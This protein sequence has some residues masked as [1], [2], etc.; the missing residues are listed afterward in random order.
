MRGT[1]IASPV[2]AASTTGKPS[3][4]WTKSSG[5]SIDLDLSLAKQYAKPLS[6]TMNQL[7][8][9]ST[10]GQPGVPGSRPLSASNQGA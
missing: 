7:Q 6:P 3:Q 9:T 5:L 8:S 2:T 10:V 4:D 1:G